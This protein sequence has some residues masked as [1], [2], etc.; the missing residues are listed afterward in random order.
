MVEALPKALVAMGH[1][2]AV[3]LPR[4]RGVRPSAN[5]VKTLDLPM[6]AATR[7]CTIVD[8]ARPHGVQY[9]LVDDPAYFD[10]ENLYGSAEADYP[11]NAERY[12]EFAYAAVEVAKLY[13]DFLGVFVLDEK[14]H[15]QSAEVQALNWNDLRYILAVSRGRTLAAAARLLG[16]LAGLARPRGDPI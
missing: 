8:G 14:D 9:F 5:A 7:S 11:D 12:A 3:L 1:E 6:G 2:V 10:R 4:Y 15:R 13:S 16:D